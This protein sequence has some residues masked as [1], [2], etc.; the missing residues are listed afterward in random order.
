MNNKLIL[1]LA[2]IALVSSALASVATAQFVNNQT[3]IPPDQ[4]QVLAPSSTNTETAPQR[5]L[6]QTNGKLCTVDDNYTGNCRN[7]TEAGICQPQNANCNGHGY[8][9]AEQ[10][11]NQNQYGWGMHHGWGMMEI[12]SGYGQGCHR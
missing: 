4:D 12:N 6:N 3:T 9:C 2:A 11:Q 1:A 5:C 10:G 7:N 8:G